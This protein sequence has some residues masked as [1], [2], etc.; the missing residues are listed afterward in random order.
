MSIFPL[1]GAG[2]RRYQLH[3]LLRLDIISRHCLNCNIAAQFQHADETRCPL[4]VLLAYKHV[5][6]VGY[7]LAVA[8]PCIA[9]I[10]RKGTVYVID[11]A[12]PQVHKQLRPQLY[13]CGL[14]VAIYV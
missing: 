3:V 4:V 9:H 12:C 8:V 5:M 11:V 2:F 14:T 6:S 10:T 7:C 1:L 13:A